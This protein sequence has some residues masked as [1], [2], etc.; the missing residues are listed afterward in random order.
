MNKKILTISILA[1]FML[2]TISFA[3]AI[4]TNTTN[5]QKRE[6]PLFKIRTKRAIG[7]RIEN[8]K[9]WFIRNRIFRIPI[10]Y[11][12]YKYKSQNSL[13][14]EGNTYCYTWCAPSGVTCDM[15]CEKVLTESRCT[16]YE[17]WCNY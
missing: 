11:T 6:T 17:K 3:T 7:E 14:S 10:L 15:F 1:I 5:T 13:V 12:F 2:V 16:V 4:N 8:I 9:I